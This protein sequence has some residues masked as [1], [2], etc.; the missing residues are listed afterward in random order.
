MHRNPILPQEQLITAK[1]ESRLQ[2]KD[3]IIDTLNSTVNDLK[4]AVKKAYHVICNICQA[5]G[6]LWSGKGNMA[7]Y[8]ADL[9]PKQ[10]NLMYAIIE[11]GLKAT[12]EADF[13]DLAKKIENEN[14]IAEG[15]RQEMPEC[16]FEPDIYRNYS[17]DIINHF[18][19][20]LRKEIKK[21]FLF[22]KNIL[23]F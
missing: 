12:K 18:G 7:E 19:L 8:A 6:A 5:A 4:V 11:Y 1:Y 9:T 22:P 13:P 23:L 16:D 10:D 2:E 17:P 15:I 20:H 21:L 14:Y 3:S